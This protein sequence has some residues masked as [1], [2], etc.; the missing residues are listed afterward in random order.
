MADTFFTMQVWKGE[1][2]SP[3]SNWS[4]LDFMTEDF[5]L[6]FLIST[7]HFIFLNFSLQ[8]VLFFSG[9]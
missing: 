9:V 5:P 1:M 7:E 8:S 2:H 3:A 6:P 4:E